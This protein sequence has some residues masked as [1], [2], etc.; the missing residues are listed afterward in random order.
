M[1]KTMNIKMVDGVETR[2][3]KYEI[4]I[5]DFENYEKWLESM[6][7]EGWNLKLVTFNGE[8]TF[9]KGRKRLI[10]YCLDEKKDQKEEYIAM[11]KD[12]GWSLVYKNHTDFLWAMEYE[13]ERPEAFDKIEVLTERNRK[14]KKN[15]LG[16]AAFYFASLI[17]LLFVWKDT[18]SPM[19]LLGYSI[20][21]IALHLVCHIKDYKFL[22]TYN[23]NK[24]L[25][26]QYRM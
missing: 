12:F 11:F 2:I 26:E 1:E 16:F 9:T 7:A 21:Y 6:E 15:V 23:K 20:F 8:H 4:D 19:V 3:E 22:K 10:R 18:L 14:Y 25:I 13:G 5:M 24:A 17:F